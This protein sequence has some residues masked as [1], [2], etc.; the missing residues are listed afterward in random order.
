MLTL[1]F[2]NIPESLLFEYAGYIFLPLVMMLV[3]D[4]SALCRRICGCAIKLLIQKM[5]VNTRDE[6]F[7]I[8]TKFYTNANVC[9]VFPLYLF[10]SNCLHRVLIVAL[11]IVT[12]SQHARVHTHAHTRTRTYARTYTDIRTHARMRTRTHAHTHACIY[13]HVRTHTP[14]TQ[15]HHTHTHHTHT[16]HTPHTPHLTSPHLTSPQH[17]IIFLTYA[18]MKYHWQNIFQTFSLWIC[19]AVLILLLQTC[20]QY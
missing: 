16:T 2:N 11:W 15:A 17:H 1:L 3:N 12:H 6:M 20:M 19:E 7:N 18:T 13:T 8:V 10:I 4:D 14:H 9:F 5:D